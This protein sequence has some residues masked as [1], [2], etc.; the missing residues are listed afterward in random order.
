MS[1]EIL[2]V[3]QFINGMRDNA[4]IKTAMNVPT[5]KFAK[6][7]ADIAPENESDSFWIIWQVMDAPD[8]SS[9]GGFQNFSHPIYLIKAC[10]KD[11]GYQA[12]KPVCDG[13]EAYLKTGPVEIDNHYIGRFVRRRIM[14][15]VDEFKDLRVY[16]VGM[17]YELITHRLPAT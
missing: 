1:I 14:R 2:V 10:V 3:D 5:G 6:V 11:K 16:W 9:M 7:Y 8:T 15:D 4:G 17:E 13:I 12:L